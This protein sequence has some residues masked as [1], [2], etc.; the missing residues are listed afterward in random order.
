MLRED[1]EMREQA[2]RIET[3]INEIESFPDPKA[4]EKAAEIV[5]G[6]L[7]LYGEGLA[8]ILEIVAQQGDAATSARTLKAFASD[9]L[10][11]NLLMLHDLHPVDVET[12]VARALEEARPYLE[13]HGGNVKLLRVDAGIAYLELEGHCK[14]CPSSTMTMKLA[15]E[16]AIR[17]A[18]PDLIGIE[19]EGMAE[20]S[21][22]PTAFVSM[23]ALQSSIK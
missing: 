15:I 10:I 23:T 20:P 9:E 7:T 13:S 22:K 3:I 11:S 1:R 18:A 16:E 12:R 4:Q 2:A 17:K 5:Q 19:A 8:R 14:G 6:L 21:P